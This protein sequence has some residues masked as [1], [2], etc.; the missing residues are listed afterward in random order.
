MLLFLTIVLIDFL[1]AAEM[2]ILV[3]SFPALQQQFSLSPFMVQ[4]V[5]SANGVFYALSSLFMGPL[6]DRMGRKQVILGGLFVFIAGCFLCF[7]ATSY[8][9]VIVGRILQG[10]GMSGSAV[11]VF[12]IVSDEY[13]KEKQATIFS[14]L[15]GVITLGMAL[16]PLIGSYVNLRFGWKGNIGFL[17]VLA[18]ISL[19]FCTLFVPKRPLNIKKNVQF[20]L[21]SYAPLF[22]SKVFL[23]LALTVCLLDGCYW[24]FVGMS[25]ILYVE[26]MGV[27]L[28]QFWYYQGA[29]AGAFALS[30]LLNP[31]L[32]KYIPPKKCLVWSLYASLFFGFAM[33]IM[34][35]FV[36][37]TPLYISISFCLFSAALVFPLNIAYPK[38]IALYPEFKGRAAA[39][40]NI[41]I[42]I[43]TAIGLQVVSFFY[44]G[45]FVYLA[46]FM[47][48]Y[49]LISFI[50]MRSEFNNT[51]NNPKLMFF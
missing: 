9:M 28:D 4:F 23:R 8:T 29:V 36:K 37:D 13:P 48:V 5:L 6:G 12:V 38:A 3:P 22:K 39:F 11:L 32:F 51:K 41:G 26:D 16:S 34:G 47:F 10:I 7:T 30:S 21:M 1:V 40:I 17:F 15:N 18:I 42:L 24:I 46:L 49:I 2:D 33:V 50:L 31:L 14:S 27:P 43:F 25:S 19:T 44:G 20:S 45:N 35:I